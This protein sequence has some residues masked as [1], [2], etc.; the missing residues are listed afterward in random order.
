MY[1]MMLDDI[2]LTVYLSDKKGHNFRQCLELKSGEN[3]A[4]FTPKDDGKQFGD[5]EL[6]SRMKF[7]ENFDG[8]TAGYDIMHTTW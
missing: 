1:H 8:N 4:R 3:Y 7:S 5:R 6:N 2:L